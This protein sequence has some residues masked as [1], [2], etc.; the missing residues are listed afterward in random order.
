VLTCGIEAEVL[1]TSQI[2]C[3]HSFGHFAID[4]FYFQQDLS[5]LFMGPSHIDDSSIQLQNTRE[6]THGFPEAI[7]SFRDQYLLITHDLRNVRHKIE[8]LWIS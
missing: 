1:A 8:L 5:N 4:V 6:S 3:G 2:D 7:A